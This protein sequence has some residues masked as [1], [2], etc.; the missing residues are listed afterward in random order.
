[1]HVGLASFAVSVPSLSSRVDSSR[2]LAGAALGCSLSI[3]RI[4][5]CTISFEAL[6]NLNAAILF[7]R[8]W[9]VNVTSTISRT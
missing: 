2:F 3:G 4:G 5:D 8:P 1:M 9:Q 6:R 7:P